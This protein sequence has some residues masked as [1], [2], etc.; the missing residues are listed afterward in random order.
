MD[1][2]QELTDV[3]TRAMKSEQYFNPHMLS[4]VANA[5]ERYDTSENELPD[6]IWKWIHNMY[7][8]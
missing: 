8:W 5:I 2:R 1:I 6:E 7:S 3:L 4:E